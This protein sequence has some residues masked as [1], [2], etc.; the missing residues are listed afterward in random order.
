M[1]LAHFSGINPAT[2]ILAT[3]PGGIAEMSLT[4]K[5]L[6]LGVPIV[7]AFH[8]ARMAIIVILIGPL[9]NLTKYLHLRG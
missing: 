5:T 6:Q 8:V 7:A 1:V 4:A 9:F 3:A 2:A